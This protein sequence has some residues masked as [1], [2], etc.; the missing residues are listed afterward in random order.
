M[1]SAKKNNQSARSVPGNNLGCVGIGHI[2]TDCFSCTLPNGQNYGTCGIVVGRPNR[3]SSSGVVPLTAMSRN[4]S[5]GL[6]I[7][8]MAVLMMVMLPKISFLSK[9]ALRI[10]YPTLV[11][12]LCLLPTHAAFPHVKISNIKRQ[13][14]ALGLKRHRMQLVVSY[15][16]T[17]SI[18]CQ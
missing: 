4:I 6:S 7:L 12:I 16:I 13:K 2:W 9:T 5:M 1:N 18:F 11:Q 3:L 14:N 10:Y 15:N 8:C 17:S